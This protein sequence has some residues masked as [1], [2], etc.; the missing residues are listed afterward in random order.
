MQ[1]G[2][3][4]EYI[5]GWE[6]FHHWLHNNYSDEAVLMNGTVQKKKEGKKDEQSKQK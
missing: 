1:S 2:L 6:R 5:R 4:K 3:S